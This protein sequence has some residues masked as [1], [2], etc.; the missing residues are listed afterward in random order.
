MPLTIDSYSLWASQ[1][2]KPE[3]TAVSLDTTGRGLA[4]IKTTTGTLARF[5]KT[6]SFTRQRRIVRTHRRN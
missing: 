1:Q 2:M 6:A 4:D 5:F 3:D